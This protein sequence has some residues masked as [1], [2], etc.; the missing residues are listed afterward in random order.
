MRS[1]RSMILIAAIGV[2]P[3]AAPVLASDGEEMAKTMQAAKA[4]EW[5]TAL[6]HARRISNPAAEAMVDWHRLRAGEGRWE[7]YTRFLARNGDWPGLELLRRKGEAVMPQGLP[8][9]D[10]IQFFAPQ[11]PQTSQGVLRYVSALVQS[12]QKEAANAELARAWTQMT[13]SVSGQNLLLS[14]YGAALKP[15]HQQRVDNLLWNG[16]A[17]EAQAMLNLIP[18]AQVPLAKARIGLRNKADGVDGLI[19]AVPAAQRNDPGLAWERLDWR[20]R[21][22]LYASSIDLIFEHSYPQNNLG[23]PQVWSS[24]RMGLVR[25]ALE[26]DKFKTAYTLASRH[27][28]GP[29]DK[30]YAELE[31]QAGY[32]ALTRHN[33][34]QKAL[35]HFQRFRDAVSSPISLGRAGYWLGRT[36]EAIGNP[37]AMIEAYSLGARYQ[38][39]FYGQLAAERGGLA[40]DRS[41]A[42]SLPVAD[43]RTQPFVQSGPIQAAILLH[44]AGDTALMH[45][46]ILHVQESLTPQQSASLAQMAL[47]YGQPHIAVR[48]AKR[49]ATDGIV[50]PQAYYPV[51]DLAEFQGAI[52]RELTMA[53]ARQESE[54]NPA[55]LSP[56][57]ARGLMQLMPGTA[58][59]VAGEL[60][61]EYSKP[62]LTTDPNYNAQLG[63]TYLA[64]LLED[65]NGSYI[66]AIAGYNAGPH[67]AR[68]WIK[69]YGDPRNGSVDPIIWI[70]SI[71]YTETR[72]YVM[73]VLESLHIYRTRING[74]PAPLQ[75][76]TDISRS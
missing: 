12:G 22:G 66:L 38:T 75:L 49:I 1:L 52:P 33:D 6:G 13:L 61:I 71:P 44:Q 55:A 54:L 50:M 19:N 51:T 32:V 24:R 69:Q 25:E 70:E 68:R 9:A 16:D 41:L 31:W 56:A 18:P 8:A 27:G 72:N 39:S 73:R 60:G 11:K 74:S 45:R 21:K 42:G 62:R 46:F 4:R 30:D 59:D 26:L 48:I 17:D 40:A 23:R 65:F 20:V 7:E 76:G 37:A 10:V 58:K 57:G 53:I 15:Y 43:W 67:R 2:A 47:E 63:T 35:P 34:P 64:G 29:S 28:L 14:Q 36:Y 5:S 3:M